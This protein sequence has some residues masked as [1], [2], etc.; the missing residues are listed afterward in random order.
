MKDKRKARKIVLAILIGYVA[1]MLIG[2]LG[3]SFYYSSHFFEGSTINGID[4][5][6]LTVD[7]VKEKVI[8]EINS[9]TLKIEERDGKTETIMAPQVKLSYVDDNKVDELMDEQKQFKWPLSFSTSKSYEMAA[10]TTFSEKAVDEVMNNM[11]CFQEENI[12]EP[13][14]AYIEETDEGFE[15]IP[16]V[17]GTKLDREKVKTAIVDA[18]TEGK[19][20]ISLEKLGCYEDPT[21]LS[22]DKELNAELNSLNKMTAANITY[23]F[24]S[25]T[26]VVDRTIIRDWLVKEDDGTYTLD[27]DK[28]A[29]YV[30]QLGVKY[31]TFGLEHKFTKHDGT[32]VTLAAGGDYGWCIN[33]TAT[34]D[35]LI[36]AVND[37]VVET[38]EPVYLYTAKS[39]EE[40]DIGDT[41]VEI[42]IQEQRMWC[43]KD[44]EEIVDTPV[45]TGNVSRG[46]DTPAN[47][48]WAIDAKQQ[49]AILDGEGYSSPVT[50]WMPFNGNVGIHD[51]DRWRSEYGG[52]IYLTNGSHGCVN[53]PY[54]NAEKIFNAVEIGTAVIVY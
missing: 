16:E 45:V 29:A 43:Y 48:V 20:T 41:Y 14:N 22:D 19:T 4:C 54:E 52:D 28:V 5:G 13:E 33:K 40:N 49:D 53:T 17:M 32:T 51:A 30:R 1:I 27:T 44:G 31:D 7:E 42:S 9:Y 36:Q 6:N 50:F 38:R 35:A 47:G 24:G 37:G 39:R 8:E 23:T 21:V 34:T 15:I 3:I 46:F 2:Y 18:I 12:I 10:N 26:E 11:S 25:R